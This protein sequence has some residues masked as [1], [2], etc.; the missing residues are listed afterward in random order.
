MQ[1][2]IDW[3]GTAE[4]W[5]EE[6]RAETKKV[7]AEADKDREL[8]MSSFNAIKTMQENMNKK[9]EVIKSTVFDGE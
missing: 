5:S 1:T 8:M 6:S 3:V 7:R 9:Q 4:N 2:T